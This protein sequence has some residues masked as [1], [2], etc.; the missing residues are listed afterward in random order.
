MCGLV[1]G[2]LICVLGAPDCSFSCSPDC[3]VTLG[4]FPCLIFPHVQN[5]FNDAELL[6]VSGRKVKCNGCKV[7][8]II[9]ILLLQ[10]F[11]YSQHG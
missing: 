9:N 1:P 2:G 6:Q 7:L 3:Q 5:G 4:K 10:K 11:C 8:S